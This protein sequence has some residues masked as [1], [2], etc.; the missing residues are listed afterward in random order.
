M[1]F[2]P[3]DDDDDDDDGGGTGVPIQNVDGNLGSFKKIP[4]SLSKIRC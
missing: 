1:V 4:V 2:A 3:D